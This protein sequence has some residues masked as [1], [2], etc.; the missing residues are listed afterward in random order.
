LTSAFLL[1]LGAAAGRSTLQTILVAGAIVAAVHVFFSGIPMRYGLGSG[2]PGADSDGRA[3][4]RIATG[5]VGPQPALTYGRSGDEP[6]VRPLFLVVLGLVAVLAF[7][8]D[9]GLGLALVA[10]FG[11]AWLLQRSGERADR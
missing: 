11:L 4:W 9:V 2:S 8:V 6:A 3:A 1:A 5:G 10:I 7:L